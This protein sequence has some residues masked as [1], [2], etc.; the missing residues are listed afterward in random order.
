MPAKR[1]REVSDDENTE[2]E[3]IQ[4]TPAYKAF[5]DDDCSMDE[6]TAIPPSDIGHYNTLIS[7]FQNFDSIELKVNE[8]EDY[9]NSDITERLE[10]IIEMIEEENDTIKVNELLYVLVNLIPLDK[11]L[12]F[13]NRNNLDSLQITRKDNQ[14]VCDGNE[15][16]ITQYTGVELL[17]HL[18]NEAF[19][20]A[21]P[22]KENANFITMKDFYQHLIAQFTFE[23]EQKGPDFPGAMKL[24][25]PVKIEDITLLQFIKQVKKFNISVELFFKLFDV[26]CES[27]KLDWIK[28]NI[29]ILLGKKKILW[30]NAKMEHKTQP[31]VLGFLVNILPNSP[32]VP[33]LLTQCPSGLYSVKINRDLDRI[34]ASK[35]HIATRSSSPMIKQFSVA[36]KTDDI[37]AKMNEVLERDL[38]LSYFD[39]ITLSTDPLTCQLISENL[40]PKLYIGLSEAI[41]KICMIITEGEENDECRADITK[42]VCCSF[43]D[44]EIKNKTTNQEKRNVSLFV[45][46]NTQLTNWSTILKKLYPNDEVCAFPSN[47]IPK[48]ALFFVT[49]FSHVVAL[50]SKLGENV[51]Y[52]TII[53]QNFVKCTGQQYGE[54][55]FSTIVC[56]K[57]VLFTEDSKLSAKI[58]SQLPMKA[59]S[60]RFGDVPFQPLVNFLYYHTLWANKNDADDNFQPQLLSEKRQ[61][62]SS[63]A[64]TVGRAVTT[65][66]AVT[67][68]RAV[69]V[70]RSILKPQQEQLKTFKISTPSPLDEILLQKPPKLFSHQIIHYVK[71]PPDLLEFEQIIFY[72]KPDIKE[73]Y[74]RLWY[75]LHAGGANIANLSA[76]HDLT[77]AFKKSKKFQICPESISEMKGYCL[78]CLNSCDTKEYYS[79]TGCN[80]IFCEHCLISWTSNI[81]LQNCPC[82]EKKFEK[83]IE[84]SKCQSLIPTEVTTSSLFFKN[85][86]F[87]LKEKEIL[88]FHLLKYKSKAIVITE[89]DRIIQAYTIKA[90]ADGFQVCSTLAEFEESTSSQC[91]FFMLYSSITLPSSEVPIII[92][93]ISK[94]VQEPLMKLNNE[95][96]LHF[97]LFEHGFDR[98]LFF[99]MARTVSLFEREILLFAQEMATI[100]NSIISVEDINQIINCITATDLSENYKQLPMSLFT[101]QVVNGITEL[102]YSNGHVWKIIPDA[103][104]VKYN[105]T[106]F[107]FTEILKKPFILAKEIAS[108]LRFFD[109][110]ELT[111]MIQFDN[112]ARQG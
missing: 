28:Q 46:V 87:E 40:E 34:D 79:V 22:V 19:L 86:D 35:Y 78:L 29:R 108:H 103:K 110:S 33:K 49:D 7:K 109:V 76:L 4:Q 50:C 52:E 43:I 8:I 66:R 102:Q 80:C 30:V 45:V 13:I 85:G 101:W 32:N 65:R 92:H 72:A 5:I 60:E 112:Q 6:L 90:K 69:T 18:S 94:A 58:L 67:V 1:Q 41:P 56:S 53:I 107:H 70:G 104:L 82:G 57:M 106:I 62:T 42:K 68:A 84:V 93:D 105:E 27:E 59:L 83:K 24:F 16:E 97:L 99:E 55:L 91:L 54:M 96:K 98:L 38:K 111:R 81:S 51:H 12:T 26:Y 95:K 89:Y 61:R 21:F 36:V 9:D 73:K 31:N 3:V 100:M 25:I 44:S 10:K 2:D 11:V 20:K 75:D 23:V 48:T 47:D 88:L 37:V 39:Y 17:C 14:V 77:V 74:S 15:K 71:T 63:R 64:V